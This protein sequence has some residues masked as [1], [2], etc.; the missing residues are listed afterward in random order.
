MSDE[1]WRWKEAGH[2]RTGSRDHLY[3]IPPMPKPTVCLCQVDSACNG[4][5]VD[6]HPA[7]LLRGERGTG[8]WGPC[9]HGMAAW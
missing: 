1:A 2:I 7:P 9:S 3:H 4:G 6:T 5:L 8:Q